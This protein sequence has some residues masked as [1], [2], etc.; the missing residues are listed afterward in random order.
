[1]DNNNMNNSESNDYTYDYNPTEEVDN[2]IDTSGND[3]ETT[4]NTTDSI[5]NAAD[6]YSNPILD[7]DVS[8]YR[9]EP[10]TEPVQETENNSIRFDY[11]DDYYYEDDELAN[12]GSGDK[13][14][15]ASMILGIISVVATLTSCFLCCLRGASFPTAVL[16]IVFSCVSRNKGTDRVEQYR[17]GLICGITSLA[18][19][20]IGVVVYV[21]SE[22]LQYGSVYGGSSITHWITSLPF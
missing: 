22:V 8:E 1:M 10:V 17:T 6:M 9:D 15:T 20:I 11:Y 14:A 19:A 13:L 5:D 3:S 7:E 4:E 2:T 12:Y 18:F 21:L 16:A